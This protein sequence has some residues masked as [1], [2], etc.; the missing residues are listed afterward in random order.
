MLQFV[1][2]PVFGF[3]DQP[4]FLDGQPD[5]FVVT[6]QVK[7]PHALTVFTADKQKDVGDHFVGQGVVFKIKA[8]SAQ[9]PAFGKPAPFVPAVGDDL[10]VSGVDI[11]CRVAAKAALTAWTEVLAF[12]E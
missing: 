12:S 6:G 1:Q 5:P 3:I 7:D 9:P 2:S 4:G 10:G 11:K 8:R